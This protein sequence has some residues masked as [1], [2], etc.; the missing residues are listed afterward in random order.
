M[1]AFLLYVNRIFD[2]FLK[3]TPFST[4]NH[5]VPPT[6]AWSSFRVFRMSHY[7]ILQYSN[8][9]ICHI[10]VSHLNRKKRAQIQL[11]LFRHSCYPRRMRSFSS[12]DPLLHCQSIYIRILSMLRVGI[13]FVNNVFNIA[14][15]CS[16]TKKKSLTMY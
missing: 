10:Q 16:V 9:M 12:L 6:V 15:I 11:A 3:R 8:S 7:F 2:L 1:I 13:L 4:Q 14:I 5:L